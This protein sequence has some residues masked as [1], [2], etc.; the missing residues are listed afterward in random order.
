M[1]FCAEE[2]RRGKK[3]VDWAEWWAQKVEGK[4]DVK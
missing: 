1:V 2:A 3:V 4:L